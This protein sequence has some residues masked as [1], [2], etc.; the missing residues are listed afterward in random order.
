M[1]LLVIGGSGLV[2]NLVMPGLAAEHQVRV[3][4]L[5]PPAPGPDVEYVEGNL[6]DVDGLRAAFD[7]VDS[8]LFMAMGPDGSGFGQPRNVQAHFDVSV[9]GLY[10]ALWA[11]HEAGIKHSVY[12]SSMSVYDEWWL[13]PEGGG[14]R[15]PEEAAPPDAR[16]FYGLSKRLGEEVCRNAVAEWG[17]SIVALRLCHP[18]ADDAWPKPGRAEVTAMSTSARDVTRA[19]LAALDY[20]GRGFEPI[21]ISGDGGQRMMS[22]AKAKRLLDWAPLDSTDQVDL[23]P[24]SDPA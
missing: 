14:G 23:K 24:A 16:S 18:A 6:R 7:G 12:T 8:M 3:F 2:G 17:L 19:I 21:T 15:F 5:K 11:A 20:K 13:T 9:T 22:L 10:F 1:R 4:D